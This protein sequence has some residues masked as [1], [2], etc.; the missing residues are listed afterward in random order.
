M[1]RLS[2]LQ[3]FVR[4]IE[5]GSFTRAAQEL[6]LGQPAISKQVAGLEAHLGTQLLDRT[7]RGLRAT[8]AGL[9][10][11]HSAIRL[12]AAFE[13]TEG[14]IRSGGSGAAGLVRVATPPAFGRMYIVP[15]L[16]A[17]FEQFPE[18][19]VEFSVAQRRVDL[20]RDG[21]D[22]ALRVGELASSNL[23]VRR[24][25]SM[26]TITV[27]APDYLAKHG[28]PND[29]RELIQHRL[30]VGQ[31]DGATLPWHF[32]S[33]AGVTSMTPLGQ[34]RSNDGE[35][36]RAAALVGLGILHGPKA[37][38]HAD[39]EAGRVVQILRHLAPDAV[40]IQAVSVSGRKIAQ[41]AKLFIDFLSATFATEPGLRP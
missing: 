3:M 9:D 33:E 7:S 24:I 36:L 37:L 29:L 39:V 15:K 21:V 8:S 12:I 28:T 27:A 1:D 38:L 20:I 23:L 26:R 11:Y 34:F 19:V 25:G 30:I 40:P 31:T 41:R 22:V 35:D 4:V 17:F 13:E 6:G 2:T 18:I 16:P 10:L 32:R 14:R 5:L